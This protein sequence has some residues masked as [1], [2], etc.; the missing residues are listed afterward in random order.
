MALVKFLDRWGHRMHL[1]QAIMRP[2]CDWYD[3]QVAGIPKD[4]LIA[5]DYADRKTP[6]WLR[7]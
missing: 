4:D 5:M 7:W 6:W 1:P 2:I 3:I